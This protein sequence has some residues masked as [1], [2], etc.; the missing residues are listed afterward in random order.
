MGVCVMS[1]QARFSIF[2]GTPAKVIA[3]WCRVHPNTA[4]QYKR[5]ERIPGAQARRLFLLHRD[6]RV[7]NDCWP[8]WRIDGNRLIDPEGNATTQGQLRAYSM[9]YQLAAELVRRHP[10]VRERFDAI[11][12]EAG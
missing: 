9:V 4:Y 2:Y 11:F 8:A 3:E 7:L 5:G 10:D 12:R 1:E 6:G